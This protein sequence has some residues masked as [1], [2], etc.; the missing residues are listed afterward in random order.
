MRSGQ[1]RFPVYTFQTK[2]TALDYLYPSTGRTDGRSDG[3]TDRHFSKKISFFFLIK[4]VYTYLDY[5]SN[6]TPILTKVS[7][8]FFPMEMGM[9]MTKYFVFLSK[10]MNHKYIII[11]MYYDRKVRKTF[12]NG[13]LQRKFLFF[14]SHCNVSSLTA[15]G[16][17]HVP[18]Y[19]SKI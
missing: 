6:F 8:P 17:Q 19:I 16:H 10:Y 4:N 3:R 5:F 7:K 13:A 12:L 1:F 18:L 11:K 2:K 14:S 15:H 9:K